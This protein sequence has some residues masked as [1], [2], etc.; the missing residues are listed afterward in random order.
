MF[1]TRSANSDFEIKQ[2]KWKCRFGRR[3]QANAATCSQQ[4]RQRA[5]IV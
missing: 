4:F 1:R 5:W 2:E 3:S